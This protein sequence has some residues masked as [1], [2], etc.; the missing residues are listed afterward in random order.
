MA[1]TGEEASAYI[2]RHT[3][4]AVQELIAEL[5]LGKTSGTHSFVVPGPNIDLRFT[6]SIEAVKR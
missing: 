2:Q 3:W 4:S 1:L 5:R 6:V